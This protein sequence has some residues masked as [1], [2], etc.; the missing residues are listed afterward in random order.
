MN[1]P[2]T[3]F[4]FIRFTNW[5]QGRIWWCFPWS[6]WVSIHTLHE[7]EARRWH[8]EWW[9]HRS[10]S[11]HTLHELEASDTLE[12]LAALQDI[13][14]IHT[15]HELEASLGFGLIFCT[16]LECFHSYASR[17]GS[18]ITDKAY[19]QYDSDGGF[20]SYASRIGSKKRLKSL[21]N[22]NAESFHSYASRIGSKRCGPCMGTDTEFKFPFI[23]FTN[24][25]QDRCMGCIDGRSHRWFPFIR[26]TNWKQEEPPH[27]GVNGKEVFP[28]IRFTNWKQ[29]ENLRRLLG[30]YS[31]FHSYASRIGS[32][33]VRLETR[34]VSL[35][36]HSYASR[37]GSKGVAIVVNLDRIA[38]SI[39][40]LHELEA[41]HDPG[42]SLSYSPVSIHTLHELE[43]RLLIGLGSVLLLVFP[44]IRFTNWKQVLTLLQVWLVL[45]SFHSYASRIGSKVLRRR[46]H[47]RR[48]SE[49]SIHTLH[50]LEARLALQN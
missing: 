34:F 6:F 28:F 47:S 1:W 3:L 21:S 12:Q 7:L 31:R 33:N 35:C 14:S 50:E 36:F 5:K 26:F 43:A 42:S 11:I 20:H 22:Y 15:L 8:F 32:K 44:F 13:V 49:V 2:Y 29:G 18:K 48:H 38:V 23:R 17:I 4:P 24:W 25:K 16:P 39:H 19:V 46:R 30:W 40:T 37:I 27:G 10:V 9:L 45:K 41:R